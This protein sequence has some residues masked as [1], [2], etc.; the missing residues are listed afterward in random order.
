MAQVFSGGGG[1][2]RLGPY[3]H[4]TIPIRQEVILSLVELR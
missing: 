2:Q 3:N 1:G 4:V